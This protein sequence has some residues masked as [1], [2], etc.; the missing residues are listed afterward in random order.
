MVVNG[1][2]RR[3][4]VV[5]SVFSVVNLHALDAMAFPPLSKQKARSEVQSAQ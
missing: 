4:S 3:L 1:L 2:N 5:K